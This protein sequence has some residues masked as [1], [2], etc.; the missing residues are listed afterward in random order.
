MR[1]LFSSDSKSPS[2]FSITLSKVGI[3]PNGS[4]SSTSKKKPTIKISHT[5]EVHQP[6]KGKT[7]K[8]LF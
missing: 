4:D 2:I 3:A 5:D 8:L 1:N 7:K 6:Q